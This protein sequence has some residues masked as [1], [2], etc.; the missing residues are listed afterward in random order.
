MRCE[1]AEDRQA[2]WR[3]HGRILS[4]QG[5]SIDVKENMEVVNESDS[6]LDEEIEELVD[7]FLLCMYKQNVHPETEQNQGM[8][9][10]IYTPRID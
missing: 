6:S 2:H 4:G 5:K 8:P 3:T 10:P 1:V 7:Q 9:P